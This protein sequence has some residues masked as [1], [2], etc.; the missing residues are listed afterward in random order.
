MSSLVLEAIVLGLDNHHL[1]GMS[2]REL[3]HEEEGLDEVTF[4]DPSL[5]AVSEF[6]EQDL[7]VCV[8]LSTQPVRLVFTILPPSKSLH[9]TGN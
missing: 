8:Q 7:I 2:Q 4:K 6:K 3:G 5:L 1:L 9:S